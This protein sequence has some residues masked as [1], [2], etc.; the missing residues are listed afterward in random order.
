M[1]RGYEG[2]RDTRTDDPRV[3]FVFFAPELQT[4]CEQN[5]QV[6]ATF[7]DTVWQ[8]LDTQFEQPATA[9]EKLGDIVPKVTVAP[10]GTGAA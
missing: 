6:A 8:A 9:G 3:F 4:L 5:A 2:R 10:A 7:L 1:V